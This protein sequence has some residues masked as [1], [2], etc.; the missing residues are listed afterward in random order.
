MNDAMTR[1]AVQ[2]EA[3]LAAQWGEACSDRLGYDGAGR[4]IA[5]RYL[6]PSPQPLDIQIVN[7]E[8]LEAFPNHYRYDWRRVVYLGGGRFGFFEPEINQD[9]DCHGPGFNTFEANNAERGLQGSGDELPAPPPEV[10][11]LP[12]GIGAVVLDAKVRLNC[13]GFLEVYFT[14]PNNPG[15]SCG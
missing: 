12:I 4:L 1:S 3:E 14:A 5:C 8:E 10:K 7:S 15:G 2:S 13:E 6:A 11:M 9:T